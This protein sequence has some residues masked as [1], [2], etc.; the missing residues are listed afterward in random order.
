MWNSVKNSLEIGSLSASMDSHL[1][2]RGPEGLIHY[3]DTITLANQSSG[4]FVASDG[5][6]TKVYVEVQR[7]FKNTNSIPR[8]F[9]AIHPESSLWLSQ[10]R[11]MIPLLCIPRIRTNLPVDQGVVCPIL[12]KG[13]RQTHDARPC[14]ACE[15]AAGS[16]SQSSPSPRPKRPTPFWRRTGSTGTQWQTGKRQSK[17]HP[18]VICPPLHPLSE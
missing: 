6:E 11:W 1:N 15:T 3:G 18:C 14:T 16:W 10:P 7:G 13:W 17:I 12:Q 8:Y 5:M 2:V 9:P 4:G